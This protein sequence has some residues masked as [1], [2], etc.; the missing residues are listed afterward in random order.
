LDHAAAAQGLHMT[1]SGSHRVVEP[2]RSLDAKVL[3]ENAPTVLNGWLICLAILHWTTSLACR[4]ISRRQLGSEYRLTLA[5]R[6]RVRQHHEVAIYVGGTN[7]RNIRNE[8]GYWKVVSAVFAVRLR[9][10]SFM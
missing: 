1:R 4:L 9:L 6:L 8:A 10:K 5:S 3:R 2:P 7:V